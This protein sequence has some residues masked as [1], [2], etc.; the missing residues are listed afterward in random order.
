MNGVVEDSAR[1]CTEPSRKLQK[2]ANFRR[3]TREAVE[4]KQRIGKQWGNYGELSKELNQDTS[5]IKL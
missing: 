5:C 3:A 1:Y 2:E 4:D